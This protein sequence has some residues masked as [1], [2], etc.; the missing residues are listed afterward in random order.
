MQRSTSHL[1][2]R[3]LALHP[4]ASLFIRT[5]SYQPLTPKESYNLLNAQ[6]ALRPSSPW[7]IV[8]PKFLLTPSIFT[9]ATGVGL[10]VAFYCLFLTH[11]VAPL[12]GH[13]LDSTA[14]LSAFS[15]LPEWAQLAVKGAVV[16][17]VVYHS[18]SGVRHLALDMGFALKV[19]QAYMSEYALMAGTVLG[20]AG[21]L[22]L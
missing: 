20:T 3:T 5:I 8:H 11:T 2:A 15:S 16:A 14:Y 9:R 19:K 1:L 6:R 12:F 22:L 4:P 13:P 10:S 21:L 7:H 18:L 17:P